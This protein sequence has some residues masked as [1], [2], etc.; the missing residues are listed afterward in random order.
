MFNKEKTYIPAKLS[1]LCN[2]LKR[3]YDHAMPSFIRLA[4]Q[5][6]LSTH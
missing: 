6:S 4:G 3:F 2:G 1:W 5:L